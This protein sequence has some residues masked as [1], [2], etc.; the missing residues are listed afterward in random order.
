MAPRGVVVRN[1]HISKQLHERLREQAALHGV[2]FDSE[3]ALRLSDSFSYEHW[4]QQRDT[5][6]SLSETR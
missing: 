6:L 4:K 5:L 2:S 1:L 3:V